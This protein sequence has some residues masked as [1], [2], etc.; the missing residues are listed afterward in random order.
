MLKN[1]KIFLSLLF[2]SLVS[3]MLSFKFIEQSNSSLDLLVTMAA[4]NSTNVQVANPDWSNQRN[5]FYSANGVQTLSFKNIRVTDQLI[6][7]ASFIPN[8]E[9]RIKSIKFMKG[10]EASYQLKSYDIV[11]IDPEVKIISKN[12]DLQFINPQGYAQ[13]ILK[14]GKIQGLPNQYISEV[15]S[16]FKLY[17]FIPFL[18]LGFLFFLIIGFGFAP[19]RGIMI[20]TFAQFFLIFITIYF[21]SKF[22]LSKYTV[23]DIVG[24]GAYLGFNPKLYSHIV[25]IMGGI[26]LIM[27]LKR[28]SQLRNK[29]GTNTKKE[30]TK[31]F[32]Y[33]NIVFL[34]LSFTLYCPRILSANQ[35][36]KLGLAL[37][38]QPS[39][40][41]ENI[42]TWEGLF[43]RGWDPNIDFWYPYGFR[44]FLNQYPTLLELLNFVIFVLITLGLINHLFP[45]IKNQYLEVFIS[46]LLFVSLISMISDPVR[47]G[48]PILGVFAIASVRP[49]SNT[50]IWV[51]LL[52]TLICILFGSDVFVY[53]SV[54]LVVYH[55]SLTL[56]TT[57]IHSLR[58][59]FGDKIAIFHLYHL[60]GLAFVY[61]ACAIHPFTRQIIALA[62]SSTKAGEASSDPVNV[63]SPAW[64][65][66]SSLLIL[67]C[68][69][70]W[71]TS[72]LDYFKLNG[73]VL[74]A[75][76][77][78]SILHLAKMGTRP[79][80]WIY[81][82]DALIL[83]VTLCIMLF[84]QFAVQKRLYQ[85][86]AGFLVGI[87]ICFPAY[88]LS[89]QKVNPWNNLTQEIGG[90]FRNPQIDHQN[91]TNYENR[92][93]LLP[94]TSQRFYVYGDSGYIYVMANQKPYWQI[95]LYNSSLPTDQIRIISEL[96]NNKPKYV[97]VDQSALNFDLV[98]HY[99]R[100]PQ[101]LQYLLKNFKIE[102]RINSQYWILIPRNPS[103][104]PVSND[105]L[106]WSEIFGT[107]IDLGWVATNYGG[108]SPFISCT[109][110][111]NF[112]NAK[113]LHLNG[114][115]VRQ[116]H[117]T[118]ESIQFEINL[119]VGE[120]S[121]DFKIPLDYIWP[122]SNSN[123]FD[124]FFDYETTQERK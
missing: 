74:T 44:I 36:A 80:Y 45:K 73:T 69:I 32:S 121:D 83:I 79:I 52:W 14:V 110:Q 93:V 114:V 84:F 106:G 29:V 90:E 104:I 17:D 13:L 85:I 34:I 64:L 47:L 54:S 109:N 57:D 22:L 37:N 10:G 2:I 20:T 67:N 82:F 61:L 19:I 28:T 40:D 1:N 81:S 77:A 66:W 108:K 99:M 76:F 123:S 86:C 101:L 116:L 27:S 96:K 3:G 41:L 89:F 105:I 18:T 75:I 11:S 31:V 51:G 5:S 94:Y 6:L 21:A 56:S 38:Q 43:R 78:T 46:I 9:I 120:Y 35:N 26:Y 118:V 119:F 87:W 39:W 62:F 25:V 112:C 30:F 124:S 7:K 4:E 55:L 115:L 103:D 88:N 12:P 16:T 60:L 68:V 50:Q 117:L 24:K 8:N 95:N 15:L 91:F 102:R 48:I 49:F 42:Q 65:I 97:I 107:K 58:R 53:W 63:F 92:K 122:I 70:F 111:N 71:I 33:P 113:L 59:Y 98:P 72:K 23:S 100:N